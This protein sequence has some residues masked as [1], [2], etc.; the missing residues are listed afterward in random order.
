MLAHMSP[1]MFRVHWFEC[2][3][4]IQL[5]VQN[6]KMKFEHKYRESISFTESLV[7]KCEAAF[8]SCYVERPAR[9]N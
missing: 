3:F 7:R 8:R 1:V 9:N 5:S 2:R 4:A 6:N